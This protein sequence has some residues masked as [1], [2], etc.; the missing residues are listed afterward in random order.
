M[1][2]GVLWGLHQLLIIVVG[3]TVPV[4]PQATV[5][6]RYRLYSLERG[7]LIFLALVW[8]GGVVALY[9]YYQRGAE[10]GSLLHRFAIVTGSE[11]V[12]VAVMYFVPRLLLS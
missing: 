1:A 4:D 10:Q 9:Y 2:I 11:L 6:T 12:F 7:G 3:L 5:A 8:L